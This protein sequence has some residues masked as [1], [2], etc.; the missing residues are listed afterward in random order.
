[1][2]A[3]GEEAG[4]LSKRLIELKNHILDQSLFDES[5]RVTRVPIEEVTTSPDVLKAFAQSPLM[6]GKKGS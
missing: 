1:L 6:Q 5:Y 3:K 2:T 4:E